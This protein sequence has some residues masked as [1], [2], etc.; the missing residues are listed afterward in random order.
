MEVETDSVPSTSLPGIEIRFLFSG[1]C[2]AVSRWQ[3]LENGPGTT[4]ERAQA[5]HVVSFAHQGAYRLHTRDACSLIDANRVALFNLAVPY[6]TS[7]PC[8]GRDS[9]SAIVVQPD[10]LHGI[11]SRYD[12]GAE[13]KAT[14]VASHG[15]C[16]TAALLRQRRLLRR[17]EA[18]PF[19]DPL[20][21][22]ECA[23]EVLEDVVRAFY[24]ER[25]QP[26][27]P[28]RATRARQRDAVERARVLLSREF[29]QPLRLSE[30]ADAAGLS[31]SHLCRV[32]P[33]E[34][35]LP[36]HRYRNRLRL[37]AAL[38]RLAEP[39]CDLTTLALDLGFS[40]HSHFTSAFRREFGLAPSDWRGARTTRNG[41]G[42]SRTRRCGP[43]PQNRPL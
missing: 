11:V 8:G 2:V 10:V 33:A 18:A 25:G 21:A 37:R 30:V 34:T 17:L 26:A 7:H 6:Q 39:G 1:S 12:P 35:G 24:A 19:V 14:F 36:V 9:G 31:A 13:A 20:E 15:P 3:C 29:S 42:Q 43:R 40:S 23:L 16:P 22:E 5:G 41:A 28:E 38:E 27:G 32:F 4:E